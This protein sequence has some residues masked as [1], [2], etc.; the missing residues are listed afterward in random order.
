[1]GNFLNVVRLKLHL[2]EAFK[3]IYFICLMGLRSNRAK[4]IRSK[5][6]FNFNIV[7]FNVSL[8]KGSL[9]LSLSWHQSLGSILASE[10][11][12]SKV[13]SQHALQ[14]NSFFLGVLHQIS[15]IVQSQ[16][17]VGYCDLGCGISFLDVT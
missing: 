8:I 17:E 3:T 5:C 13:D 4:N 2:C 12:L 14:S 1:M 7:L 15:N 11:F 6:L 10:Y 9:F 16:I